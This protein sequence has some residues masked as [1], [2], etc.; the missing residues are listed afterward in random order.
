MATTEWVC[1][2][3]D[4]NQWQRMFPKDTQ[5]YQMIDTVELPDGTTCV[6]HDIF[7]LEDWRDEREHMMRTY[8]YLGSCHEDEFTDDI[9]AECVFESWCIPGS[10]SEFYYDKYPTRQEA[11]E[12]V[13]QLLQA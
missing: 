8:G 1:T 4:T 3:P 2:D 10:F 12:A 7:D 9:F 6:F 5:Y 13:K 11:D